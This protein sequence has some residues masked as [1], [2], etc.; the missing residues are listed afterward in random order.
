MEHI[1]EEE[2][3]RVNSLFLARKDAKLKGQKRGI[4]TTKG[5]GIKAQ[6]LH[7]TNTNAKQR[8]KRGRWTN[9][10]ALQELGQLLLN[11]GKM[12]AIE[13]FTLSS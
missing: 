1:P 13:A 10:E 12:K 2:V 9:N 3:A 7:Q 11:L 5:L 8:K 6:G 4:G